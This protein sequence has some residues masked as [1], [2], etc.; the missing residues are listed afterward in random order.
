MKSACFAVCVA[1][2][3]VGSVP[4]TRAATLRVAL[5][6]FSVDDNSYRSAAAVSDFTAALQVRLTGE[7]P[8]EW[9]ER[10]Q[11]GTAEREIEL[12][13]M[14]EASGLRRGQWLKADM[15][16]TGAFVTNNTGRTLHLEVVDVD[17]ADVL[18]TREVQLAVPPKSPLT[19]LMGQLDRIA[20]EVKQIVN[21]AIEK[22]QQTAG[23]RSLAVLFLNNSPFNQGWDD[24]E[25][26]FVTS[27]E[28]QS[29]RRGDFR[30]LR[31]QR[32]NR[33]RDEVS[34]VMGGLV[35]DATNAFHNVADV[36]VWGS[37][38]QV[39]ARGRLQQQVKLSVWNGSS[40]PVELVHATTNSPMEL[41]NE[42][43]SAV[44]ATLTNT[45]SAGGP[46]EIR[47][48]LSRELWQNAYAV[49]EGNPSVWAGNVEGRTRLFKL[50]KLFET[51]CFL[52]PANREAQADRIR[53]RWG[54]PPYHTARE[55][56]LWSYWRYSDAWGA[57]VDR[58]G[59]ELQKTNAAG[60]VKV[61]DLADYYFQ[62]TW[63]LANL[64]RDGN[65]T[66]NGFPIDV[67]TRVA[68]QWGEDFH[69]ELVRRAIKVADRKNLSVW[70][71]QTFD[72]VLDKPGRE[73][74]LRDRRLQKE[75]V[76][77]VWPHL[78]K[79][80]EDGGAVRFDG[81]VQNAI[82]RL[83]AD[84]G[85]PR[86]GD[87]LFALLK[88][89]QKQPE[90]TVVQ[91]PTLRTPGS[92]TSVSQ[93]PAV[94]KP[95][96]RTLESAQQELL[97]ALPDWDLAIP[98]LTGTVER[99]PFPKEI[100]VQQVTSLTFGN[101]KVWIVSD[102]MRQVAVEGSN[103]L[104][105]EFGNVKGE[106]AELWVYDPAPRTMKS[107]RH[108]LPTNSSAL[109]VKAGGTNVWLGATD[110]LYRLSGD[111][112]VERVGEANVGPVYGLA[113][114]P[115]RLLAAKNTRDG[116]ILNLSDG[117]WTNYVVPTR[118]VTG[119]QP[120]CGAGRGDK[121]LLALQE[122]TLLDL[123]SRTATLLTNLADGASA[124]RIE[125]GAFVESDPSGFWVGGS[126]GLH[127]VGERG[128]A[129]S[130]WLPARVT[131]ANPLYGDR[132]RNAAPVTLSAQFAEWR[133]MRESVAASRRRGEAVRPMQPRTKLAGPVTVLASE[134]EFLW[135]VCNR[136]SEFWLT[137]FHKQSAK[138]VAQ[139]KL[140]VYRALGVPAITLSTD[141]V[142]LG[143]H[144]S[145]FQGELA[146]LLRIARQDFYNVPREKWVP[147]EITSEELAQVEGW[148]NSEQAIYHLFNGDPERAVQSLGKLD[149]SDMDL[150]SL[151]ALGCAYD[152]LGLDQPEKARPYFEEIVSREGDSPWAAEARRALA[153]LDLRIAD[154]KRQREY[155]A[156]YDK[157]R[158]GRIDDA[159][160]E[161][162]RRDPQFIKDEEERAVAQK[163]KA[164]LDA[165][166]QVRGFIGRH[167]R[168]RNGRLDRMEFMMARSA[169]GE[170]TGPLLD[171]TIF[172]VHDTNRNQEL[173]SAEL[174]KLLESI[175]KPGQP[176]M[177]PARPGLPTPPRPR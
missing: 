45:A 146:P 162:M 66:D 121:A 122:V 87:R 117:A 68:N 173:D 10:E 38:D 62:S 30:M 140:P 16:I 58:F 99:V 24:L 130:R 168:N 21:A 133:R 157:N 101:G 151:Y 57:H 137:L 118:L 18:A 90:A 34:L 98:V 69:K 40:A 127:F 94:Q 139:M 124:R 59:F 46:E 97:M 153:G 52:D 53:Y 145:Q 50:L 152:D 111:S 60:V 7:L 154:A 56:D 119:G 148:K 85:K 175:P 4:G 86:E 171:P 149:K 22:K 44:I 96:S 131:V 142:W 114:G 110:G 106:T 160:A 2:S 163:A 15:M 158:D 128:N 112:R 143:L 55:K 116:S 80:S 9:I 141:S 92:P 1:L 37:V 12:S 6:E 134:Q 109:N 72:A 174:R 54:F 71:C 79:H 159:E 77:G 26:M 166:E 41:A 48:R 113:V 14:G 33:A 64:L 11:L 32:G 147:D 126:S 89:P 107:Q 156:R 136:N 5:L 27:L 17:R 83:Y 78:V 28:E 135:V 70:L 103:E 49:T 3:L 129:I 93:T 132:Q 123:V 88:A 13:L 36:Y 104:E 84:D 125:R 82:N 108:L 35:N 172:D 20:A 63:F 51:A 31:F 65:R 39:A 67:P 177:R 144:Q 170:V 76:A 95:P 176:T 75:L 138:W 100:V 155:L 169:A 42:L 165:E 161:Q 164:D 43:S 74:H 25:R 167:D 81:F 150:E 73:V 120:V 115:T 23:R 47:A 105:R 61:E 91:K 19:G 29:A 8:V 102:G